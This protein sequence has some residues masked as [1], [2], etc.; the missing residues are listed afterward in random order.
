MSL[1]CVWTL[2]AERPSASATCE[3]VLGSR[4]TR[5][6]ISS[7]VPSGRSLFLAT[8]AHGSLYPPR[9]D[10]THSQGKRNPL[11]PS[12]TVMISPLYIS[13]FRGYPKNGSLLKNRLNATRLG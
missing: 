5:F 2:G 4:A 1:T 9:L 11:K 12:G 13:I 3:I 6:K 10:E 7:F 8:A